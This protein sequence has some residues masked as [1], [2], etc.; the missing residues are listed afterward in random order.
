MRVLVPGSYD[1]Y[2]VGHNSVY[3]KACQVFGKG[4][5]YIGI[6]HHPKKNQKDPMH[7]KW[8]IN[9]VSNNSVI[10]PSDILLSDFC[11]QN[12]FDLVIRSMRNSIDLVYEMDMAHWNTKLG[13]STIF[14]PCQEGMEKISSSALRELHHFGK[15]VSEFCPPFVYERWTKK[16]KRII[17]VGKI[18]SGKSS[19]IESLYQREFLGRILDLDKVAR[20]VLPSDLMEAIGS[21]VKKGLSLNKDDMN[22]AGRFFYEF[23]LAE[24]PLIKIF[25]VSVLGTYTNFLG[26]VLNNLYSDSIIIRIDRFYNGKERYIDPDFKKKVLSL[27]VDP[28][29]SDFIIDDRKQSIDDVRQI[30][31]LAVQ[32]INLDVADL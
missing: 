30:A 17:I 22:E 12:G 1:P 7:T 27:Q 6:A 25:E 2:T 3:E 19:F 9:A 11:K 24:D 23:I 5:V 20:K 29:I 10:I 4:N 14:I 31:K 16:P 21:R 15:D 18:G 26:N 28:K 13:I 8:M 32:Q